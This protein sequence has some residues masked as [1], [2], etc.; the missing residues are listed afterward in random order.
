M[1]IALLS[2]K[3]GAGKST[4]SLAL[5]AALAAEGKRTLIVDA[6]PQGTLTAWSEARKRNEIDPVPGLDIVSRPTS[7]IHSWVS[8]AS[9]GYAAVVIDG[10]PRADEALSRSVL[11]GVDRVLVPLQPSVADLWAARPTLSLIRQAQASGI[12]LKAALVLSRVKAGTALGRDFAD[13]IRSEG[14]PVLPVG[15]GDRVSYAASLSSCQT[16]LEYEPPSG[17]AAQETVALLAAVKKM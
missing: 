10:P 17:R 4:I 6:D 1:R 7:D 12:K 8:D 2:Q 3:G 14:F 11:A 5:A 13:V 9:T 15:T 16:I